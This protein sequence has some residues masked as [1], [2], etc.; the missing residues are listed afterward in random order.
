MREP[1]MKRLLGTVSA[2]L[3]GLL[4]V[5]LLSACSREDTGRV[6]PS[7]PENFIYEQS[8]DHIVIT[9]YSGV[10]ATVSIPDTIDGLPVKAIA[11]NAF[12]E[13]TDLQKVYLPDSVETIDRAFAFCPELTYVY[14]GDGIVSM[15]G[16]FRGC[17]KLAT[18]EG[19]MTAK[20]L[21]E[22]FLGCSSLTAA[23][24]PAGAVS[25]DR[26]FASC[27]SL[28][29]VTIGEGIKALT[30]TFENCSSLKAA[31]LPASLTEAAFTFSGCISLTEVTGGASLAAMEDTFENCSLLTSFTLSDQLTVMKG[32]FVGCSSLAEVKNLPESLS[33]YTPSF[34]GC[35]SLTSLRIPRIEDTASLA[36][37][38]PIHDVRG[39]EK[40]KSLVILADYEVREEFCKV[41]AGCPSLESVTLP[42]DVAAAMLRLSYTVVDSV[43]EGTNKE[44][45][46][47]VK[48]W[49]KASAA[50]ETKNYAWIDGV[51]YTHVYGGDLE[52]FDME[53]LMAEVDILAFEPFEKTSYWCGYP[54]GGTRQED[55]VGI[56]RTYVFSLRTTGKNDGT[57][58]ETLTLNGFS[59]SVGE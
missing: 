52:T 7:D 10:E 21:D 43:F 27:T 6:P 44:L 12:R 58:P 33:V 14:L 51:S 18:L 32:A 34:T 4:L 31:V 22:A 37:Y 48:K 19:P 55:T 24:I 5:G 54:E 3:L 23:S 45:D 30:R 11:E 59:C 35:R 42:D 46:A 57:L 40:L 26:A 16:A 15:K 50:R 17:A 8:D 9:G 47:A 1:F 13:L 49:K 2:L 39:C 25:A 29:E 38:N 41:F 28:K 53:E 36:A 20:H 56:Q